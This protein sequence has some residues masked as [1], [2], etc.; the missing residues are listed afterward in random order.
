M[1]HQNT[2]CHSV[3]V[4]AGAVGAEVV[5]EGEVGSSHSLHTPE[6][7]H[8]R[9]PGFEAERCSVDIEPLFVITELVGGGGGGGA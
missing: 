8:S 9:Y 2:Q 3:V 6:A 1:V 4:G 7:R 5:E